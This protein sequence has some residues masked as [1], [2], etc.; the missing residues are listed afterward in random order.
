MSFVKTFGLMIAVGLFFII[1]TPKLIILAEACGKRKCA[2]KKEK[3]NIINT[4]FRIVVSILKKDT[5][6]LCRPYSS[7]VVLSL[8]GKNM[9]ANIIDIIK[10]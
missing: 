8:W 3:M 9:G 1:S 6:R 4:G 2:F 10:T 7:E 5:P